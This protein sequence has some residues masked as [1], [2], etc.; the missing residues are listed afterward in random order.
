MLV[1]Q[2]VESE[3]R[4][5]IEPSRWIAILPSLIPAEQAKQARGKAA[6]NCTCSLGRDTWE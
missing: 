6:F 2:L 1:L 4:H 5:N 3:I